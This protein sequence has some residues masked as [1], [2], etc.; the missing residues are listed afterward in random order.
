M[1]KHAGLFVVIVGTICLFVFAVEVFL[2]WYNSCPI[3]DIYL[4][5]VAK[6]KVINFMRDQ[7]M[8]TKYFRVISEKN[9]LYYIRQ[10][11]LMN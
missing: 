6:E 11:F 7:K 5:Q 9:E 8:I 3:G 1:H 10:I 2:S 4:D